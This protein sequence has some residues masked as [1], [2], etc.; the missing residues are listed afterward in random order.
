VSLQAQKIMQLN[1]RLALQRGSPLVMVLLESWLK[2]EVSLLLFA[3]ERVSESRGS[4]D[5]LG[6]KSR[7][8][9][10]SLFCA[11]GEPLLLSTRS[12]RTTSHTSMQ[13]TLM[14]CK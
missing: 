8:P 4:K 5:R 10:L 1:L 2:E 3:C 11:R 12:K 7:W 9:K 14:A 6:T 13:C